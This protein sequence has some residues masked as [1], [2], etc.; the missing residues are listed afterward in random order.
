VIPLQGVLEVDFG[1]WTGQALAEL[2]KDPLWAGVQFHPSA[3]RFPGGEAVR[4]AQARAVEA[5]EGLR[6]A[7]PKGRV[8]VVSHADV[9]RLVLAH[10]AGAHLDHFQRILI[11]PASVSVIQLQPDR[12]YIVAINDV[13]ALPPPVP[14]EADEA[15]DAELAAASDADAD[16]DTGTAAS[17]TA[18]ATAAAPAAGAA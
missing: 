15:P 13:G 7:H 5:V 12:P 17:S 3:A 16:G 4:G 18:P 1:D 11:A 8:A 2:R 14:A 9:I 6:E 10:Y